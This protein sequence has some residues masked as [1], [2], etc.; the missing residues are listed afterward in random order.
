MCVLVC[1]LAQVCV[2]VK[3]GT[4]RHHLPDSG[5]KR[6]W[7]CVREEI[8]LC[9]PCVR[10]CSPPLTHIHTHTHTH[11]G[12]S[13]LPFSSVMGGRK[14]KG[15]T[16]KGNL[17]AV[18]GVT[19][20]LSSFL[21]FGQLLPTG[22][23]GGSGSERDSTGKHHHRRRGVVTAR[24]DRLTACPRVPGPG[25]SLY[26][27][28]AV[29]GDAPGTSAAGWQIAVSCLRWPTSPNSPANGEGLRNKRETGEDG[30]AE[31]GGGIEPK[32]ER[33]ERR[34]GRDVSCLP[35][36]AKRPE[37]GAHYWHFSSP[38]HLADSQRPGLPDASLEISGFTQRRGLCPHTGDLWHAHLGHNP[39]RNHVQ[40][41]VTV[42]GWV[43]SVTL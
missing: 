27:T 5:N 32:R 37:G 43:Y 15:N 42:P 18:H 3:W 17:L 21:F 6:W 7:D 39:D 22:A 28:S 26:D 8:Y 10:P 25:D 34:R 30:V 33:G 11:T 38:D 19:L 40:D 13:L 12:S 41:G 23:G 35:T 24:A 14:K 9:L 36:S 1:L 2:C 20:L 31:Q 29:S 4:R 16:Q